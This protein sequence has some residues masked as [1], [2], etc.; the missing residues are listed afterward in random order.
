ML[1]DGFGAFNTSAN[2]G[3]LRPRSPTRLPLA[4]R[5][6]FGAR[7]A[8]AAPRGTSRAAQSNI[9]R[10]A[11]EMSSGITNSVPAA[12]MLGCGAVYR[13]PHRLNGDVSYETFLVGG[14]TEIP[15]TNSISLFSNLQMT[16]F[17]GV[18]ESRWPPNTATAGVSNEPIYAW[19]IGLTFYPGGT[20]RSTTVAGRSWMPYMPVANNG[21]FLIDTNRLP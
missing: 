4:T 6:V 20:A 3:Q 21:S 10:S 15:L 13:T 7:S 9:A 2:F 12:A 5:L 19:M 16:R 8:T 18:H 1:N 14:R 11:K 17:A